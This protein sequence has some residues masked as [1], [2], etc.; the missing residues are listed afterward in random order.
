VNDYING[1]FKY[2]KQGIN[3]H[4]QGNLRLR[5]RRMRLNPDKAVD[6]DKANRAYT[7]WMGFKEQ[8]RAQVRA[9]LFQK[10]ERSDR[11]YAQAIGGSDAVNKEVEEALKPFDHIGDL[12]KDKQYGIIAQVPRTIEAMNNASTMSLYKKET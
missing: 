11:T 10:M 1:M 5:L 12:F 3:N 7:A 9:E 4:P 8:A 6:E 2:G